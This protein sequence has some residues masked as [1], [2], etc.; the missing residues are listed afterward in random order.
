MRDVHPAGSYIQRLTSF[1]IL[2]MDNKEGWS[3]QK[4]TN[5]HYM[6]QVC[7]FNQ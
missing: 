1:F 6:L 3:A 7:V 4:V 5:I 2:P